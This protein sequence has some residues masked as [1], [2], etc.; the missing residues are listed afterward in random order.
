MPVTG[1]PRDRRHEITIVIAEA[2]L[3]RVT[4]QQLALWW[5][6]AQANPAEEGAADLIRG[7]DPYAGPAIGLP[8]GPA[9]ISPIWAIA[10]VP[11]SNPPR[12]RSFCVD[13]GPHRLPVSAPADRRGHRRSGSASGSGGVRAE[14]AARAARWAALKL[15]GELSQT[16]TSASLCE[17]VFLAYGRCCS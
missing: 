15:C 7:D 13:C 12:L 2:D 4:D 1:N 6:L 9:R 14:S 10:R 16:V 8:L 11:L 5:H 3:P 17:P